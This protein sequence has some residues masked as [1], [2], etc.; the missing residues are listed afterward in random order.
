MYVVI[1]AY[2]PDDRM[3]DVARSLNQDSTYHIV[4]VDDGSGKDYRRLFDALEAT[5]TVLRHDV[6]RG[7]GRAMK[8]AFEYIAGVASPDDG[9]IA[10]DADGQHLTDDVHA[11]ADEWRRNPNALVIGGRRFKGKVPLRNRTGNAITRAV[12]HIASGVRVYDTQTGLRAFS[13]RLIPTMLGIKG[14]RYEYEMKQLL[15]AA[16]N[17]IPIIEIPIETVYINGNSTSH[18]RVVTDSWHVYKPFLS[19]LL[20]CFAYI[21]FDLACFMGLNALLCGSPAAILRNNGQYRLVLGEKQ[22]PVILVA[23]ILARLISTICF[24][25]I[26]RR[27]FSHRPNAVVRYIITVA[28]VSTANYFALLAYAGADF[29]SLFSVQLI[30]SLI[31]LPVGLI[32]YTLLGALYKAMLPH[33]RQVVRISLTVLLDLALIACGL[34][35]FAWF[36]HAKPVDVSPTVLATP[37]AVPTYTPSPT[38]TVNPYTPE[39][40]ATATPTPSPT[41]TPEPTGLLGAKF[42]DK[43]TDGDIIQTDECYRSENVAIEISIVNTT[44]SGWACC[45]YV[46]DIY[47]QDISSFC[48]YVTQED[49]NKES[50]VS[51]AN[52][53]NAILATSGDYFLFKKVGLAVRQGM[54]YRDT[55][56][57]RQ[58]VC[59]MYYDGTVETYYAGAV[60]MEH[61]MAKI[62]YHAW[63]FGPKLLDGGLPVDHFNATDTV[64]NYNPRC[65][66]GYYEPGHYCL[67]LVDGRQTEYSYG[68]TLLQ[69][70]QLMYDLGCTDAYNLDG[71]MTAMMAYDG[72]LISHPCGGGRPNCDI[73]YICEP[74]NK[75]GD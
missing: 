41:P 23:L 11:V 25:L 4:V 53:N 27:R 20:M 18:F 31:I 37:T 44:V 70:S 43:F 54:L 74:T 33:I 67:V 57:S 63:S 60:D 7:K 66:F 29:S 9:V 14:E 51:M 68:M 62:P 59:V 64:Q 26:N 28:A 13:V 36:H 8:T 17:N 58:D 32:L 21:G 52:R 30:S 22:I 6:N 45:Y 56:S 65:A 47:V 75:D 46:A 42:A 61:I 50:V 19:R 5:C 40:G 49:D 16:D 35:V 69:L 1:P 48:T 15:Y 24:A 12:F 72:E 3:L 34:L 55:L 10:V 73:V 71:G 39:P 38:P 2:C